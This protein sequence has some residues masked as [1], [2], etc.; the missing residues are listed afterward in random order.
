[1][2]PRSSLLPALFACA[3]SMLDLHAEATPAAPSNEPKSPPPCEI[4]LF[5]HTTLANWFYK[6]D[7]KT[8]P[9]KCFKVQ[10]K[11]RDEAT[12]ALPVHRVYL[13]GDK[14]ELIHVL[15][16][17]ARRA[18]AMQGIPNLIA[19]PTNLKK[20]V[21]YCLLFTYPGNEIKWR[22]ALV[23]LGTPKGVV[24][25][26]TPHGLKPEEFEFREKTLLLSSG[27]P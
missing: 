5:Q 20:D 24:A 19:A 16:E 13:Y 26:V 2:N 18:R 21:P 17:P 11:V 10:F 4:T 6:D 1:M 23:V 3:C 12:P 8:S 25:E 9:A 7:G 22:F 15:T 27:S 14:K